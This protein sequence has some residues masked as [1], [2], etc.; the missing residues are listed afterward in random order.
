MNKIVLI[1]MIIFLFACNQA[2]KN[3]DEPQKTKLESNLKRDALK[4]VPNKL[5]SSKNN[6]SHNDYKDMKL[7]FSL[8]PLSI[9]DL[10]NDGLTLS[11]KKELLQKGESNTWKIIEE[12]KT[13]LA[14]QNKN[15]SSI[16]TLYFLKHKDDL[17]GVLFSEVENGQNTI[18]HSWKYFNENK[19]LQETTILKKY[20]ASDFVSSEDKLPDSY[21]P[22]LHYMFIDDQ[23]IEV[24]VHTWMEKEF[25][26][27]EIINRI[28]L[29]WN[30]LNFDEKIER[31]SN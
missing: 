31:I 30:G 2:N 11:E 6:H 24:S 27:R 25:E 7:L 26:N 9:F 28:F 18:L 15:L 3:S 22:I 21:K 29:K 20:K 19:T 17:D 8:S 5:E 10:T 1:H 4:E 14:V 16:V 12:S 13:K 23:T